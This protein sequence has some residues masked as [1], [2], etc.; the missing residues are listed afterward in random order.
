MGLIFL[1]SESRQFISDCQSNI[2]NGQDVI[3][4]L[5]TGCTHLMQAIDG[6]TLSGAAYTAG[7]G[8]FGET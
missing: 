1:K 4:D 3:Q 6:K 2:Q 8:L 5:K 7:K